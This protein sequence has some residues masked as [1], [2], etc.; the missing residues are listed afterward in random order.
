M[1]IYHQQEWTYAFRSI[2]TA[3]CD[4]CPDIMFFEDHGQEYVDSD[5]WLKH[6]EAP[7]AT[8]HPINLPRLKAQ[9][10]APQHGTILN[11]LMASFHHQ[12]LIQ[13][14]PWG[15]SPKNWV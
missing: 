6:T 13:N 8:A 5:T 11:K 2:Q 1:G 3:A 14:D 7:T 12:W 4:L 15:K 9:A 10:S